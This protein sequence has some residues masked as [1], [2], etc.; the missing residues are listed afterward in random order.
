MCVRGSVCVF[1][2]KKKQIEVKWSEV[3]SFKASKAL[4][5]L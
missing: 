1:S 2:K 4:E 5:S 3:A